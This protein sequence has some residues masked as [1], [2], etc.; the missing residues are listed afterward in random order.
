MARHVTPV[1]NTR[2][3]VAWIRTL[4]C[5]VLPLVEAGAQCQQRECHQVSGFCLEASAL[6]EAEA[7]LQVR[8][9]CGR[10][11]GVARGQLQFVLRPYFPLPL[12]CPA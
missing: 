5:R 4:R 10:Q 12:Y 11:P 2:S 9:D 1:D 7:Q 6:T 3:T 8:C